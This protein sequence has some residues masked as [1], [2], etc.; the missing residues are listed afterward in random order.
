MF[1]KTFQQGRSERES[2]AY[3]FQYVELLSEARTKLE[4]F[5][6]IR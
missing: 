3:A 6:N 5:F 1:K 2:E 4:G